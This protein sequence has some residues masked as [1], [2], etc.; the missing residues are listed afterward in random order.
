MTKPIK[1]MGDAWKDSFYQFLTDEFKK[2]DSPIGELTRAAMEDKHF[3]KRSHNR[4]FIRGYLEEAD[5]EQDQIDA[6]DEVFDL[7]MDELWKMAE[8]DEEE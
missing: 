8:E 1:L 3:P 7:Y 5:Y 6:F 2:D 4:E